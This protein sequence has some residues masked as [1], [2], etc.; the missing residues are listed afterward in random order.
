MTAAKH[1]RATQ[2]R[3]DDVLVDC[4][5]FRI[6]KREETRLLGPR[7]FDLLVYLIAQR[8]RVIDKQELFEQVWKETF[9][10]DNA[11]TKAV[12]EIR[13]ALG[14]STDAPRYIETVP[15]RGYRFIAELLE[16]ASADPPVPPA[17]AAPAPLAFAPVAPGVAGEA[18]APTA[19]AFIPTAPMSEAAEAVERAAPRRFTLSLS[20]GLA[21]ALALIAVAAL[22]LLGWRL[23][24]RP[25]KRDNLPGLKA[26]QVT[27]WPGLDIHPALAPDGRAIAY[28]SDHNGAFEIY[29]KPLAPGSR[30]I[31]ITA[32]G[33]QNFEPA[34]SPDGQY[35]AYH[36]MNRHGICV[37]PASGGNVKPITQFGSRPAWSPDGHLIAFQTYAVTDLGANAS[38]A[39]PPS[40]IWVVPAQG[41]EPTPVTQV[42]NPAGGH[43]RPSW[44]PDGKRLAFCA[45]D[46]SARSVWTVS[47]QGGDLKQIV[48]TM[49][50][51]PI[52]APDGTGIYYGYES[53][54]YKI[55]LS[56]DS[57]PQGEPIE[58]VGPSPSRLRYFTLSAD[59]KKIAYTSLL[60]TSNIW[61]VSMS[62]ATHEANAA[63]I[64]LTQDRSFRNLFPA[65]SPDGK[66]IAFHSWKAN[67]VSNIWLVDAD[68]KNAT[69]IT[70]EGGAYPS[71][72]P[73]GER[74][75]FLSSR[76]GRQAMWAINL[77]TGQEK[78]LVDFSEQGAFMRL[79]PDGKWVA[80]N[81]TR[82]GAINTAIMPI[83]GGEA[84][85]LTFDK[86][87]MG[88]ACW[89][90]DSKLLAM[91]VGRGDDTNVAI[92]SSAGG[93][94][95]QLTFDKGQSWI[96][97]FSPDGDRIAFAGFRNGY[98][99]IWWVSRSTRQQ[100]QVT[101]YAKLNA[102]VRYPAW[103]PAGDQ[104]AYEYAE[105]TGNIW[106][107]ELQ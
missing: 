72:F 46:F 54:L 24:A 81:A 19:N 2:Y 23:L 17:D 8:G 1:P 42:G 60:I 21:A 86:E 40:T 47:V 51:D 105:T 29:V 5:N 63:P 36:S 30:E 99:N 71:W 11:L 70:T 9:V 77:K 100:K 78:S 98:W 25:E 4:E 102:Y 38:P 83:E 43:G 22:A 3:F 107:A 15:K 41:G 20:A 80:L 6:R 56:A 101:S 106:L 12:K 82:N 76:Q 93:E 104:I 96:Y 34:W 68:A 37:V 10:T 59:G 13:R 91:Q 84:K 95:T 32:D 69:Q 50:Y 75:A 61:S 14:D 73:D 64:P 62:Q 85:P 31:Q 55:R 79:S 53:G 65:W 52:Y 92:M 87:L 28:S 67:S 74:V 39:M 33:Q 49:G 97:S 88:F 27:T 26:A 18:A 16:A 94:I 35:L 90:P 66:K 7:A 89:S 57:Q 45:S 48:P 44:S 103:S 58:L